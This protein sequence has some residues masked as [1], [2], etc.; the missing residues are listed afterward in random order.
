MERREPHLSARF[1]LR[2][3]QVSQALFNEAKI[4]DISHTPV[5]FREGKDPRLIMNK[6]LGMIAIGEGSLKAGITD[7]MELQDWFTAAVV[8]GESERR[9]ITIALLDEQGNDVNV[10]VLEQA[11]PTAITMSD[12][13]AKSADAGIEEFKFVCDNVRRT[14]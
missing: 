7:S 10:W 11:L 13:N 3:D 2:I 6:Q 4:P 1:E 12:L 8:N 5:E 14:L 9:D